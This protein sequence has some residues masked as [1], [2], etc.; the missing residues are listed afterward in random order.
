M[1]EKLYLETTVPSYLA[2][3]PSRD[4]LVAGH[5]QI[6]WEWWN[7]RRSYFDLYISQ[8]VID[9]ASMGDSSVAQRRMDLLKGVDQL[10]INDDIGHLAESIIESGVI[11]VKAATDAAHIAVAAV[12]DMKYLLTWN[13]SH[14][15][16]AEITWKV[17]AICQNQGFICPIVCT[18][19]EL[20]G[21]HQ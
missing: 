12:H 13:C 1:R 9:E 6:T 21:D 10:E 15:A 17:A 11:P 20:M 2:A 18:P 4:L 5:Q 7:N 3:R 8:F 19:E 16:N 14:I